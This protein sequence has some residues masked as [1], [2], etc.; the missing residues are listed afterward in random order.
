MRCFTGLIIFIAG[1]TSAV[2]AEPYRLGLGVNLQASTWEGENLSASNSYD[3]KGGLSELYLSV[4]HERFYAGFSVQGSNFDF[5]DGAPNQVSTTGVSAPQADEL[6]RG[7]FDLVAGYFFWDHVSLFLDAKG[8]GYKWKNSGLEQKMNG[9]GVGVAGNWPIN[10][11]WNFFSSFG[12]TALNIKT[13]GDSIGDGVGSLFRVGGA[14]AM[15]PHDALQLG[16]KVQS[17]RLSYDVGNEQ[18]YTVSGLFVGYRH[19]FELD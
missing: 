17:H 15:T 19:V 3:T 14:Y 18:K 12:L 2:A 11:D 6:Q 7:E 4:M 13:G 8:E 10:G 16:L 5:T 9:L 1:I